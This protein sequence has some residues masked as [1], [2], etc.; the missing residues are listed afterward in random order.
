MT[1]CAHVSVFY[2]LSVCC[3]DK[4]QSFTV[5]QRERLKLGHRNT[6]QAA[7]SLKEG[8]VRQQINRALVNTWIALA[9]YERLHSHDLTEM[10]ITS[11]R[12]DKVQNS[13]QRRRVGDILRGT[14]VY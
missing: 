7:M 12:I 9:N 3:T 10:G 5:Y 13:M 4:G 8:S 11:G 2:C 14:G 1:E 6:L